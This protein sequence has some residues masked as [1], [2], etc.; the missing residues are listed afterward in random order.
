MSIF[1]TQYENKLHIPPNLPVFKD[2]LRLNENNI[3]KYLLQTFLWYHIVEKHYLHH[4][5]VKHT[6]WL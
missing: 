3:C 1:Y 2:F 6:T 4:T 5:E